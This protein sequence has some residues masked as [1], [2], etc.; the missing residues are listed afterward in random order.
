M[1]ESTIQIRIPQS[2]LDYGLRTEDIQQRVT[3]WLALS[4]FTEGR[5]SSGKAASLLEI[6]RVQFLS[7]LRHRGV[8]YVDYTSEEIADELSAAQELEADSRS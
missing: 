2:L 7:L 8:A 6:T 5:I 4:L 3:E 1:Q